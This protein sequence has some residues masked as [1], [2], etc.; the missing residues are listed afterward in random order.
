MRIITLVTWTFI[1]P[2]LFGYEIVFFLTYLI[3]RIDISSH[4]KCI[5]YLLAPLMVTQYT[6]LGNVFGSSQ[7]RMTKGD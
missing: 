4:L 7:D 1:C 2:E 3:F 5:Y 6:H